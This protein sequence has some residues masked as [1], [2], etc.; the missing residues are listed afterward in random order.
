M[1]A[2]GFYDD[3]NDKVSDDWDNFEKFYMKK[4]HL[5]LDNKDSNYLDVMRDCMKNERVQVG[6]ELLNYGNYSLGMIVRL[7]R[8]SDYDGPQFPGIFCNGYLPNTLFDGFSEELK[9]F[10]CDSINDLL[11]ED[12][13]DD[14]SSPDCRREALKA[15]LVLFNL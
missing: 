4:F 2:W 8:L 5:E 13:F 12:L 11:E 9:I 6:Q 3:E 1:G 15:Q 14:W 10:V 7:A